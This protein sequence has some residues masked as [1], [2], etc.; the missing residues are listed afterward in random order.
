MRTPTPFRCM[1]RH[2]PLAPWMFFYTLYQHSC[3]DSQFAALSGGIV[4]IPTSEQAR[5]ETIHC[6]GQGTALRNEMGRERIYPDS[7]EASDVDDV[8]FV[9]R[10]RIPRAAG[11]GRVRW[12]E[13]H[14]DLR[15]PALLVASGWAAILR[16]HRDPAGSW[17]LR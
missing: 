6:A 4:G 12:S 14:S 9:S 7:W 1:D 8:R 17:A 11:I 10:N 15:R 3:S 16:L 13:F 5:M 2:E